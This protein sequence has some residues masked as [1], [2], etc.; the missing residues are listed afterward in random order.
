MIATTTLNE[1]R[2]HHPCGD[3]WAKLLSHLGKTTPDDELLSL[4]TVFE[5]NGLNDALWCLRASDA[6]EEQIRHFSRLCALDV[7]HLWNAPEVVWKYLETGDESLRQE[8]R[9]AAEAADA[10][11]RATI[12][13]T[14]WATAEA[15]EAAL[16]AAIWATY[17]Q[18]A[19][20]EAKQVARF[21]EMFCTVA[22]A[23]G[24]K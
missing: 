24:E 5:S 16:R 10:A 3:G 1:I 14:I 7:I 4:E 2:K 18:R 19:A 22:K 17:R 11:L 13:A 21:K 6:P 9:D 8:V 23:T 15:V 20:A 12:W